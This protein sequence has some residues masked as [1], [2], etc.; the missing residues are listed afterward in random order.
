MMAAPSSGEDRRDSYSARCARL[1]DLN[2][3]AAKAAM[4]EF[5]SE[6]YQRRT[7]R[8]TLERGLLMEGLE[9]GRAAVHRGAPTASEPPVRDRLA[10]MIAP[11]G[12]GATIGVSSPSPQVGRG[13]LQVPATPPPSAREVQ[14]RESRRHAFLRQGVA[15]GGSVLKAPRPATLGRRSAAY[16]SPTS[17]LPVEPDMVAVRRR[18]SP[19]SGDDAADSSSPSISPSGSVSSSPRVKPML[20]NADGRQVYIDVAE[21]MELPSSSDEDENEDMSQDNQTNGMEAEAARGLV[22]EQPWEVLEEVDGDRSGSSD[23]SS[24]GMF[25]EG[26]R[27]LYSLYMDSI[28]GTDTFIPG[29]DEGED[30]YG[31]LDWL[32]GQLNELC[33]SEPAQE[34]EVAAALASVDALDLR[35]R[36][37]KAK[38]GGLPWSVEPGSGCAQDETGATQVDHKSSVESVWR[39]IGRPKTRQVRVPLAARY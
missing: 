19:I 24:P 1:L 2:R 29:S 4:D 32:Q 18:L 28:S 36:G 10:R 9:A 6:Q 38:D 26:E 21:P 23:I 5:R 20:T 8:Q 14:E 11:V 15:T 39:S 35:H 16:A 34:E 17:G 25:G 33:E 31:D 37:Q 30:Q 7:Q 3:R 13:Y 27:A 22:L 12:G